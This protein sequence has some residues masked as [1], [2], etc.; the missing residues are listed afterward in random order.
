MSANGPRKLLPNCSSKPSAV[1]NRVGGAI[2]PAL[3][4]SMSTGVP[5]ASSAVRELL[6]GREVGQ[7]H[8]AHLELRGGVRRED[9][10]AGRLALGDGAHREHHPRARGGEA[11]GGLPTGAAVGAGDDGEPAGLVGNGVHGVLLD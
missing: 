1:V 10:V 3:L 11:L 5:S 6:D 8:P 7:V 9:L 4:S 2:T